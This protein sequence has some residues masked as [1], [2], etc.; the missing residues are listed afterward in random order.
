MNILLLINNLF[1]FTI[2]GNKAYFILYLAEEQDY[3]KHLPTVQKII[4]IFET[5]I[6]VYFPVYKLVT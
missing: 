6:L 4:D 1:I 2:K 3:D 5:T